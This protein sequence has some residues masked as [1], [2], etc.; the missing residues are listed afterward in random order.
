MSSVPKGIGRSYFWMDANDS[1]CCVIQEMVVHEEGL[2][3][4]D[5]F[6]RDKTVEVDALEARE[7]MVRNVFS[8]KKERNVF[9]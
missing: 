2:I 5:D 7:H 4:Q 9:L 8:K 1:I 6:L 3:T